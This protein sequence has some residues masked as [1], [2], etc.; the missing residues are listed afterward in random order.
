M[1]KETNDYAQQW[2]NTHAQYL[3]AHPTSNVHSWI[4]SG[5]TT[6][7]EMRA[8]LG[9]IFNMG[10]VKKATISSYW[11]TCH[12]SQSTPW[13]GQHF[14]RD[15][16]LLLLKFLH[17]NSANRPA[18]EL[19][20]DPASKTFKVK[21]LVDHFNTC[22]KRLYHPGQDIAIDESM[23]GYKGKTPHLRMFMPQKR[24]ARFGIKLWC[25][26]DSTNGYTTHFEIYKGRE[27][28]V[29]QH[30]RGFTYGLVMRLLTEADLLDRGHHLGVDNFFTSPELFQD[31]FLRS[32]P[33]TGTVRQNR[34]GLPKQAINQR[35]ANRQVSERRKGNLLCV[36]YKDGGKKPILLS[37]QAK[38]GF[39]NMRNR[40]G[41]EI[42]R[43]NIVAKYNAS[44]GGVDL[45]DARLY[46]YLAERRTM[47]WTLKVAF[48]LFGR[49]L[50]NAFIIYQNNAN[51][52]RLIRWEFMV[53]VVEALTGN[54]FPKKKIGRRRSAAEMAAARALPPPLQVAPAAAPQ[55]LPAGLHPNH[56]LTQVP[57]G[58]VRQ[59]VAGHER[60]K[61]SRYECVACN[62]G[63][64]V[65][66]FNRYHEHLPN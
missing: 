12:P 20:G 31:L 5:G 49:A 51:A 63:L 35:L 28:Q 56:K 53:S 57:D 43:P 54:Y 41:E 10:L 42:R 64:C 3:Q 45:S 14:I 60:R 23:I 11:D 9:I 59:C 27:P 52:P 15:R 2:I 24:H 62:V 6:E 34:R 61:R 66:C 25:V 16:F 47:K 37:T 32:T 17:F 19:D 30:P 8:F 13:F 48:S 33:A 36:A 40:R 18:N 46:K 39:V 44:M 7:L 21:P 38:A 29:P 26:C 65:A 1:V 22:F 4:R 58:K 50:L 55:P